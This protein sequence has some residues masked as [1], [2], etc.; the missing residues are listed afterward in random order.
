MGWLDSPLHVHNGNIEAFFTDR[1]VTLTL[2]IELSKNYENAV[3][4]L[5]KQIIK[6][7]DE[8]NELGHITLSSKRKIAY[9]RAA[10]DK[11][12]KESYLVRAIEIYYKKEIMPSLL[13]MPNIPS[14]QP[15][16]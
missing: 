7:L 14:S 10:E 2:L 16:R 6:G 3:K 9:Q 5:E 4:C 8:A 15:E 11:N 13:P 12:L 1:S